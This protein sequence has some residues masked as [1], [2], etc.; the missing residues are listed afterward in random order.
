MA[1]ERIVQ[2]VVPREAEWG[3]QFDV[4]RAT[5]AYVASIPAAEREKSDAYFEGGYWIGLWSALITVLIGWLLLRSRFAAHV[6]DVALRRTSARFLQY[7]ICSASFLLALAVLT[8]P[9]SLYTGDFREHQYGMS[10]QTLGAFLGEWSIGLGLFVAF[11]GLMIAG[12]YLLVR[13]VRERWVWWAMGFTAIA[14]LFVILV[15]P[16]FVAPL[17]ND[18]KSLPEGETRQSILALAE[19]SAIPAGDVYWFDASRQT[20]RISAN[21]S[22]VG[23]TTRIA[24]NDNL[25]NDT[26]LPE[27]RAVMGHEM[28]HYALNHSL[29]LTVAFTL[30]FGVGYWFVNRLFGY[31]QRR[32]GE[33]WGVRELAD[34]AGLPLAFAIFTAVMLLLSPVT[35]TISRTAESQADASGLEAAREPHGFASVAMRLASYRKIEPGPVEE[36]LFF[37]HPSGRARVERAMTWLVQHPPSP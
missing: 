15:E 18:Y 12:L 26:S 10:N 22:G 6:R 16:V 17:F 14:I 4:A 2:L 11:G 23:G 29:W 20:K 24:L 1:A 32:Y 25:L 21:V 13:R 8:L 30:A 36:I 33:R 28:G 35:N 3:P 5:D 19:A 7:F 27:I 37:G 9:W 31:F 34:A